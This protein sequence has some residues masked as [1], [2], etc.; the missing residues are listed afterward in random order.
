[1]RKVRFLLVMVTVAGCSYA[2]TG[3]ETLNT[4]GGQVEI[5]SLWL[6][7]LTSYRRDMD[8]VSGSDLPVSGQA[9]YI[10]TMGLGISGDRFFGNGMLQIDFASE[11]V[12][13]EVDL[14]ALEDNADSRWV[15]GVITMSADDLDRTT[16]TT[17]LVLDVEGTLTDGPNT[18]AV[19]G[20]VGVEFADNG[21]DGRTVPTALGGE[22]LPG[23][24]YEFNGE[25]AGGNILI[26]GEINPRAN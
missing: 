5:L 18:Y 2:Y 8:P 17:P 7:D 26:E 24:T 1:M 6:S 22:D 14:L 11:Q 20:Q 25:P 4:P 13:G 12:T 21:Y 19:D 3:E 23:S 16:E 10:T 9:R 15:N